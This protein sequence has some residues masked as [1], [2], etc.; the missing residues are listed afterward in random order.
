MRTATGEGAR[1]GLMFQNP[2]WQIFNASVRDEIRYRV[3]D[4]DEPLYEWL[5]DALS[6]RPYEHVAPLLLSEGEKKR[7]AL[8]TLLIRGHTHGILL[9][10]PTLGQD[11]VHRAILATSRI[12]SHGQVA[13]WWS[14][15]TICSGC[16]STAIV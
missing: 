15:R 9:D 12:A 2:N 3:P 5:L 4:V 6:L 11:D 8:A 10:E 14:R 1:F 7:L 16:A 13:S